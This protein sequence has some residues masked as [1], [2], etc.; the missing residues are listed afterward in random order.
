M[1]RE[2]TLVTDPT[3]RRPLAGFEGVYDIAADGQIR[4]LRWSPPRTMVQF[5]RDGYWRVALTANGRQKHYRVHILLLKSFVGP[6]GVGEVT[7]HLN[8]DSTDNSLSNLKWGTESENAYDRTRHGTN[9]NA[10][11]RQCKRGH[12]LTEPNLQPTSKRRGRRECWA[13][14]LV[15]ARISEH[16]ATVTYDDAFKV[17][18]DRL[19]EQLLHGWRPALPGHLRTHC[20]LG[21]HLSGAN[22]RPG[23]ARIGRRGCRACANAQSRV[24]GVKKRSGVVLELGPIADAYYEK[25]RKAS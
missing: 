24:H 23:T 22:L 9:A 19:Y 2:K 6:P 13:C 4:S 20:P 3:E 21:H 12:D 11:K 18:A 10:K 16:G 8:G 25:Y 14:A 17:E 7:R 5:L 1:S 15:R